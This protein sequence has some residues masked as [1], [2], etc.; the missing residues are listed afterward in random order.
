MTSPLLRLF[1]VFWWLL[2]IGCAACAFAGVRF[3][4]EHYAKAVADAIHGI[5]FSRP[6]VLMPD[7]PDPNVYILV[8]AMISLGSFLPFA[9]MTVIRWII[10]SRWRFGPR[11]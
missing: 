5:L 9:I 11:W 8:G 6:D 2:V 3:V 7:I 1:A 10:T 4:R